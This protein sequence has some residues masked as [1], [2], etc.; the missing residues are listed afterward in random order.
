VLQSNLAAGKLPFPTDPTG[1]LFLV[2]APLPCGG[3]GYHSYFNFSGARV[4][5]AVGLNCQD[6][7]AAEGVMT[8]E[9]A[10]AASDPFLDGLWFDDGQLPWIGEVGDICNY[11]PWS[12]EGGYRFLGIWSNTAAASGG[13]PC[14]PYSVG[15]YFNVSPSPS[16]PQTVEAGSSV[17]FTLTGWSTS[18]IPAWSLRA[19]PD[20]YARQDFDTQPAFSKSIINNG[21]DVTL[22]LHVPAGTSSGAQAT[23]RV[24]SE[25]NVQVDGVSG[26]SNDW[27]LQVRVR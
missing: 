20:N 12:V 23:V 13:S 3:G 21:L 19:F 16:A 18:R 9:I 24:A 7:S 4:V 22:T 25:L 26:F 14:V 2:Y 15:H 8:H 1:L 5:Y 27:S 17:T 6:G 11:S 10:E